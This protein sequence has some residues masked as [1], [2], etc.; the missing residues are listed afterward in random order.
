MAELSVVVV[1]GVR[2]KHRLSG[3][4]EENLSNQVPFY[5]SNRSRN[6][7]RRCDASFEIERSKNPY[8]KRC[9]RDAY[10]RFKKESAGVNL[11][12]LND[13]PSKFQRLKRGLLKKRYMY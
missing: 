10:P 8:L 12:P 11:D 3:N 6:G 5:L 7:K 4:K 1:K 13:G 2:R 9:T